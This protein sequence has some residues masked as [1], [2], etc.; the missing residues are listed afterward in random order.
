MLGLGWIIFS[1]GLVSMADRSYVLAPQKTVLVGHPAP[2]PHYPLDTLPT[3]EPGGD[4]IISPRQGASK[5]P[6]T[7]GY[8]MANASVTFTLPL[9]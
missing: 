6:A 7:E 3:K 8:P 4:S 9:N 1:S 2:P 5:P